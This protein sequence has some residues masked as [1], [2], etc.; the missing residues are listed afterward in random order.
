MCGTCGCDAGAHEHPHAHDHAAVDVPD[1]ARRVAVERSLLEDNDARARALRAGLSRLGIAA[2][3]LLGGPGAG[4][5]R[6]LEATLPRLPGGARAEAVVEGDCATDRDARRIAACG[7][8]VAQI[9]TGSLCH[10]D[11]ALVE[12]ALRE[13][14]LGGV[15]RLW[16]ENV[17]NL[18]CPAPFGC[19]EHRRV[20]VVSVAEGDDKPEKYPALF[21]AVDLLVVSKLDLL[22]HTDFDV[23]R[24]VAAARAVRPGLPAL[25]LSARTGQG[26]DPWLAWV[27]AG[28]AD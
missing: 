11:A 4:K 14:D 9:E 13:L 28:S 20:A 7:A 6:L 3:G 22:P 15:S 2:I 12:A 27:C 17:G 23:E 21:A 18:V 26:L 19:G 8:R 25:A 16:I 10:L 1:G 5:T 24:C